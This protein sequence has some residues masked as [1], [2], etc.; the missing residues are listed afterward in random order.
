[1]RRAAG[2]HADQAGRDLAEK[3]EY[4]FAAQLPG[5][6]DL[7][8]FVDAVDLEDVLGQ[9]NAD[10]ANLHVD[11]P[12][13]MIRFATITHWHDSMPGAGVVHPIK[14]DDAQ[15]DRRTPLAHPVPDMARIAGRGT[16]GNRQG[17][18]AD[19]TQMAPG[20]TNVGSRSLSE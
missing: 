2:F 1:M 12:L 17:W 3:L 11:D 20:G 9:I 19:A 8:V 13:R 10:G 7:A 15:H 16:G 14:S 4:L 18:W 5:N 6:D